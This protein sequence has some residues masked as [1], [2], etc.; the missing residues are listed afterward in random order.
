[1]GIPEDN[2]NKC[3]KENDEFRSGLEKLTNI[4]DENLFSEP[5]FDS[6]ADVILVALF[7]LETKNRHYTPYNS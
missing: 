5:E 4:Q 6:R 1:L 2:L 7:L 3:V